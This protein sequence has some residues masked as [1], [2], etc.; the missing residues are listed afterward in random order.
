MDSKKLYPILGLVVIVLVAGGYWYLT[1]Q[2]I[3]TYEVIFRIGVEDEDYSEFKIEG[4][5]DISSYSCEVGVDCL[6]ETFPGCLLRFPDSPYYNEG[7]TNLEITFTL[8]QSYG[9]LVLRLVR[10]GAET[11]IV[12]VDGRDEY[13]VTKDL[14]G[15]G[16]GVFGSFDLVLGRLSKGTHVITFS[17]ADDGIGNGVYGWDALSLF[18]SPS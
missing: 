5:E 3:N 2:S 17:V 10:A 12:T 1:N 4:W 13:E 7:V 18:N 8:A 6:N 16:E 9:N 15:S 14:L 11:T